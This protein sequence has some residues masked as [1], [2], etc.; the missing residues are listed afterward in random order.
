MTVALTAIRR[1]I[2]RVDAFVGPGLAGNPA[3]VVLADE[4]LPP[5]ERQAIGA[6]AVPS[7]TAPASALPGPPE[8]P[9]P[10]QPVLN[11]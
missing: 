10:D 2:L 4:Q 1:E 8:R 6:P 5:E 7:R 11:M 3:A 9:R